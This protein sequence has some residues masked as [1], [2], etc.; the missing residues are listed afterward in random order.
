MYCVSLIQYQ[1]ASQLSGLKG[2]ACHETEYNGSMAIKVLG[3]ERVVV[4]FPTTLDSWVVKPGDVLDAVCSAVAASANEHHKRVN[5]RVEGQE[6]LPKSC[7]KDLAQWATYEHGHSF[8]GADRETTGKQAF[9]HTKRSRMCGVL[10][11]KGWL[12]M[13]S[14]ALM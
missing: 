5:C 1:G 9:I 12:S 10:H 8:S 6:R 3:L 7:R 2:K 4:A 11:K 14:V 13:N